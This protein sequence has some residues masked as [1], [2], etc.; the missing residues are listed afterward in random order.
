MWSYLNEGYQYEDNQNISGKIIRL[1]VW[2]LSVWLPWSLI[3]YWVGE[4]SAS[5]TE[6]EASRISQAEAVSFSATGWASVWH[7]SRDT[8][9]LNLYQYSCEAAHPGHVQYIALK[10]P[11][12]NEEYFI[13]IRTETVYV[14]FS[15][16]AMHSLYVDVLDWRRLRGS[17]R[18]LWLLWR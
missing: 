16:A 2:R 17:G 12:F 6:C 9:P 15:S 14:Q 11:L 4:G 1:S 7:I 5:M 18:E 3:R 8:L 10:R 13:L